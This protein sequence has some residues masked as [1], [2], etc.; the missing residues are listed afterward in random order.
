MNRLDR[1]EKKLNE[2]HKH[3]KPDRIEK[4]DGKISAFYK[5]VEKE[6]T[7][8]ELYE[9][10]D[11][12]ATAESKAGKIIVELIGEGEEKEELD[13]NLIRIGRYAVSPDL[14]EI[15]IPIGIH[16]GDEDEG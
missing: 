8:E 2:L 9:L 15:T 6:M 7:E 11:A 10:V 3:T 4:R 1:L 12:M 14:K 5:S 16:W 13:P